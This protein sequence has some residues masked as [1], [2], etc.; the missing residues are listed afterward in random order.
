[1]KSSHHGRG[2]AWCALLAI[3]LYDCGRGVLHARALAILA[4]RNYQDSTTARL[5]ALPDPANPLRWRG[6]IETGDFYAVA[7]V[8]LLRDFDPTR[9]AV[10]HKPDPNPAIDAAR[11]TAT[12]QEF[13]RFSQY[14]LWRVSPAASLENGSLVEALDMRFGSPLAPGFMAEALVDAQLRS[15]R[16]E[17]HWGTVRPR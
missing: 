5:A 1:M 4:A 16:T 8:D 6:L 3:L 12:F 9:A 17:F 13:L 14:P 7:D 10:F 11:R 2:F 15:R